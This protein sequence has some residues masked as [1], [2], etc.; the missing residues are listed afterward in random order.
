MPQ[1]KSEKS[2]KP[3]QLLRGFKD[4]L[5]EEQ[6]YWD[7][8]RTTVER[9]A[10]TFSFAR[11]E[12]PLLEDANLFIRSVGKETDIVEK[13]MY[14]F[15]DKSG[16]TVALRPEGTAG[17]VRAY[18]EHGMITRPQPVKMYYVG[19]FFRHDRPQ[20]GRYRQFNQ[21]GFE[22]I[23]DAHP[24]IDALLMMMAYTIF[25]DVGVPVTLQVNSL[26]SPECRRNYVKALQEY[27]KTRKNSLPEEDLK[28]LQTNPLRLLDSKE[29]DTQV[30]VEG[31]PQI[32]DFLDDE[33]NKHFI[34]VLEHLD[35]LDI[36][37]V[38]NPRLVRGL[39]YYSR[40]AFEIWPVPYEEPPQPEAPAPEPVK[41]HHKPE[42]EKPV[43]EKLEK[44]DKPSA[45]SALGGGGRY[46]YLVEQL[47][48]QPTPAM[49]FACGIERLILEMKLRHISPGSVVSPDIFLAQLGD[50]ARKKALKVF[51]QLR[52]AGF[53]VAESF[54]KNGL[55]SQMEQANRLGVKYTVIIGQK[56]L[57]DDTILIRDMES[58]IQE[59][60]DFEKMIPELTKRLRK[61]GTN[62]AA[63]IMPPV[64]Q[65]DLNQPKLL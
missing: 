52:A 34:K 17:V 37:Y 58:G 1:K 46:D 23:G 14:V 15:E 10:R 44:L 41:G 45:Q 16:D 2:K 35:E 57:M 51:N 63:P 11:I 30:L 4:I 9:L 6:Q 32:V 21:F 26:G 47:G 25:N 56:E 31:A 19:P 22:V 24:V 59:T 42:E 29:P 55:K 50:E 53:Q 49:G 39:D 43:E 13:E 61:N 65:T 3:L 8:V 38:L 40:T 36:P 7:Y 54:S 12:L 27:F 18:I 48:G 20:A 28:R 62:G 60:F 64:P 5:P 33:S